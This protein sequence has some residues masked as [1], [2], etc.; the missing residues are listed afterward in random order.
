MVNSLSAPITMQNGVTNTLS[1]ATVLGTDLPDDHP[2]SILYDTS[3]ADKVSADTRTPVKLKPPS[4]I[5]SPVRLDPTGQLQC[6]ACHDP[7]DN[8]FGNFL[9]ADNTAS[10]I[11]LKCHE[12]GSWAGAS[13]NISSRTWSGIGANPWPQTKYHTLAD[14]ACE[15][16]H[17][18]H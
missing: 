17:A 6:T 12:A 3:L 9:V 16:C 5:T 10:A 15:N 14:N 8:Q 4:G 2:V 18:P 7:H 11:C 13:H 1:G